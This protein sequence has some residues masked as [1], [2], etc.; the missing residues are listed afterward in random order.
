MNSLTRHKR[1]QVPEEVPPCRDKQGLVDWWPEGWGPGR[2]VEREA[3]V[4]ELLGLPA[5]A[6]RQRNA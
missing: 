1:L 2:R 4:F 5:R 3:D 6:P